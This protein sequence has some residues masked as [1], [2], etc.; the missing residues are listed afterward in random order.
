MTCIA[1]KLQ[2][3]Y[4][5]SRGTAFTNGGHIT[6]FLLLLTKREKHRYAQKC[7]GPSIRVSRMQSEIQRTPTHTYTQREFDCIGCD[8]LLNNFLGGWLIRCSRLADSPAAQRYSLY[9][10]VR[11]VAQKQRIVGWQD[12]DRP[13]HE[14]Q[15]I[16]TQDRCHDGIDIGER[17]SREVHDTSNRNQPVCGS[18]EIADHTHKALRHH[19][20]VDGV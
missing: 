15:A 10:A 9:G 2:S 20:C 18:A 12:G 16:N 17:A 14:E 3:L 11:G 6:T 4:Y 5:P 13:P 8:S 19:F 7:R 1:Y